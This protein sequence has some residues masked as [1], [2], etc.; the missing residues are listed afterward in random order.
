MIKIIPFDAIGSAIKYG[1][2]GRYY[3][4]G[5]WLMAYAHVVLEYESFGFGAWEHLNLTSSINNAWVDPFNGVDAGKEA[6]DRLAMIFSRV[7]H[8]VQGRFL[9][10]LGYRKLADLSKPLLVKGWSPKSFPSATWFMQ[11]GRIFKESHNSCHPDARWHDRAELHLS[12][13]GLWNLRLFYNYPRDGPSSWHVAICQ[14]RREP[15]DV[16]AERVNSEIDAL[17]I[18]DGK[19]PGTR[20]ADE[21]DWH[22]SHD[23]IETIFSTVYCGYRIDP[24]LLCEQ[25]AAVDGASLTCR[26]IE[27]TRRRFAVLKRWINIDRMAREGRA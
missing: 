20:Y 19:M 26:R 24:K 15:L 25:L 11:C 10:R 21:R 9:R 7:G 23:A 13:S 22:K 5:E 14:K 12:R 4:A 3:A 2:G 27:L 17:L 16:F 6:R 8:G 1:A 18:F